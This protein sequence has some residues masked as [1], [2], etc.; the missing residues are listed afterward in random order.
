MGLFFTL[1]LSFNLY[2]DLHGSLKSD[3]YFYKN[4]RKET[5]FD[6][7][8]THEERFDK[9]T[10][11]FSD[12]HVRHWQGDQAHRTYFYPQKFYISEKQK[13]TNIY[14]GTKDVQLS[15]IDFLSPTQFYQTYDM[16]QL[17]N[18]EVFN[19]L[20]MGVK[21]KYALGFIEAYYMPVRKPS[22]LPHERSP[23]LPQKVYND[24]TLVLNLPPELRYSIS[25][26]MNDNH[27][28]QNNILLAASLNLETIDWR[29]IYY[30]GI[31]SMPEITPQVS[32]QVL[33]VANPT[34]MN[35][36]PDVILHVSDPRT[37]SFGSAMQWVWGRNIIR[38]ENAWN[39]RYY[40]KGVKE[41][42]ENAVQ[43]ERMV[44]F[45]GHAQGGIQVNYFWN[46]NNLMSSPSAFSMRQVINRSIMISAKM[47]WRDNHDFTAYNLLSV[48]DS[49]NYLLGAQYKY[50]FLNQWQLW[51]A[52]QKINGRGQNLFSSF[53]EMSNISFGLQWVY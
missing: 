43:L 51:V 45:F 37:E 15:Y 3:S 16:S 52:A 17:F 38:L 21:Q 53:K 27:T 13:N 36:D 12:L 9:N 19:P 46:N 20:V 42:Q 26:R 23:W 40:T 8:L 34:I 18:H 11:F 35:V 5:F 33:Q 2:A 29:L 7:H 48:M 28:D 1:L 22:M 24:P 25:R 30:N 14:L 50:S 49:S 32:G 10:Q 4:N 41:E 31:S 47:L 39:R 44:S 6:L